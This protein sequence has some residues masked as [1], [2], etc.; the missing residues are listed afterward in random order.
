MLEKLPKAILKTKL[1]QSTIIKRLEKLPKS[2]KSYQKLL[3][4]SQKK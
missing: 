2:T 4:A 1:L 3:K